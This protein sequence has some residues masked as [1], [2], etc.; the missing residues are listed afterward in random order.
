MCA[1]G[2]WRHI[3]DLWCVC[4][5]VCALLRRSMHTHTPH[6]QNMPPNSDHAHNKHK[7]TIICNFDQVQAN[8]PWW[9][10]LCDPKHVGVIFNVC[11]LDFYP[12][13][14]LTSTTVSTECISCLI[15]VLIL[16][17]PG[18]N[19]I[20]RYIF[21]K[22]ATP[23]LIEIY[24][25]V[26]CVIKSWDKWYSVFCFHFTAQIKYILQHVAF[27]MPV[28]APYIARLFPGSEIAGLN[29]RWDTGRSEFHFYFLLQSVQVSA[30]IMLTQDYLQES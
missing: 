14:I 9:W 5:C 4:V 23:K 28:A 19:L 17:M 26:V 20:F 11:L 10:I 1:I 18:G 21:P 30:L 24:L 27:K 13:Q 6:V 3:L 15:K 16:M 25:V 8:N 7:W 29:F 2:V 12:T 22:L